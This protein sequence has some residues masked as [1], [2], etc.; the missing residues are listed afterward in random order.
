MFRPAKLLFKFSGG[1]RCPFTSDSVISSL[2]VPSAVL[3]F[4]LYRKP[5]AR[6]IFIPPSENTVQTVQG[7][8]KRKPTSWSIFILPQSTL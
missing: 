1:K 8:K 2:E 4:I 6:E 3:V 5:E 7:T